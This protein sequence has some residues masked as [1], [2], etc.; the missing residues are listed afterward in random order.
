VSAGTHVVEVK[1]GDS[2]RYREDTYVAA[3]DKRVIT[4]LSG[5]N[6]Q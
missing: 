3:G 1:V 2:V 4:V 5:F 6:P